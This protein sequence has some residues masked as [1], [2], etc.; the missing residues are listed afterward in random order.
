MNGAISRAISLGQH[1]YRHV[2]V[3]ESGEDDFGDVSWKVH[4]GNGIA[5]CGESGLS[6]CVE[7]SANCLDSCG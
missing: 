7:Y 5:I 4:P 1:V 3:H 2:L 6:G